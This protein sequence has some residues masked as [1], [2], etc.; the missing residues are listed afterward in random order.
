MLPEC[1]SVTRKGISMHFSEFSKP[2]FRVAFEGAREE[3]LQLIDF[4]RFL[5]AENVSEQLIESR[6]GPSHVWQDWAKETYVGFSTGRSHRFGPALLTDAPGRLPWRRRRFDPK[7]ELARFA[8]AYPDFAVP[9]HHAALFA[10][11]PGAYL[12][13]AEA[14]RLSDVTR[15]NH[16]LEIGAGNAVHTAWRHIE[17]PALRTIV[18]DLPESMCAG[19]FLL[20]MCGIDV[21]LP[22]E[23]RI[24]EVTM[25]LPFQQI[26][27][28][29]D[30]A[31]NMSSFQEMELTVVNRYLA[32]VADR[33]EAGGVLQHVNLVQSKQFPENRPDAYDLT[34]FASSQVHATPYHSSLDRA[35]PLVSTRARR[36]SES[37]SA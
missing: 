25:R 34:G 22:H 15:P 29:F 27:G 3:A 28:K 37:S 6:L 24:A 17:N 26:E 31:F 7:E 33:L 14:V 12:R 13:V 36:A 32:L 8:A 4:L 1:R 9:D 19:Y 5:Y 21:A 30:F 10:A 23:E 2:M 11:H 20:R 18:I 35:N 16:M